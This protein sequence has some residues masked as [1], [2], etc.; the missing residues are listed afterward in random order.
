MQLRIPKFGYLVVLALLFAFIFWEIKLIHKE[1][2]TFDEPLFIEAGLTYLKFKDFSFDPFNP[3]LARELIALPLLVNQT[4]FKDPI[5]LLSRSVVV[6]FAVC[7]ALLV[8]FWS[9]ALYGLK[10]AIFSLVILF[11]TPEFLAHSHYANTDLIAT[12][13]ALLAFFVFGKYFLPKKEITLKKVLI[14]C[15][16]LGLAL[17][18]RTLNIFLVFIPLVI[19]WIVF[20]KKKAKVIILMSG[21]LLVLLTMWS[22]YFFT[23]EPMLGY[24]LDPNRQAFEFIKKYPYLT[25][26]LKQ[27][28]PLGSYISTIKNNFLYNQ[29]NKFPK[30]GAFFGAFRASGPG[31]LVWLIFLIKTPVPLIIIFLLI[32][33]KKKLTDQELF[34]RFILIFTFLAIIPL[35]S[36]LRLRYFLLIY[37]ILAIFSGNLF[38][39]FWKKALGKLVVI[40]LMSWMVW[41][42]VRVYPHYLA[43]FNEIAGGSDNGYKYVVDSNLDWGQGLLTLK[44]FLEENSINEFQLAYFGSGDPKSYGFPP[45]TRV[46]DFS[47]QDNLPVS[48]LNVKK[49]LIISA[50]CWYYCGYYKNG[51]LASQKPKVISGQFLLF[52]PSFA[53]KN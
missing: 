35:G 29:T 25:F 26:L 16:S 23:S 42:A 17:A 52:Y 28:V 12:F 6:S 45:Y 15:F 27:P 9:K 39:E 40:A 22:T 18:A 8:Y 47:T 31:Y 34:L 21:G 13:F 53:S 44:R 2:R 1:S 51:Y 3:P 32:L 24:R 30:Y 36:N 50:S 33:F 37:P 14:F 11:L 46:K 19:Y 4:S 43:Y 38:L 5:F 41:G 49:P 20:L 48:E 10:G 7:L